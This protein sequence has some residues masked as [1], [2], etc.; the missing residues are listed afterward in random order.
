MAVKTTGK[1]W[2]TRT[3]QSR[4]AAL[5]QVHA[6]VKAQELIML[7]FMEQSAVH[8]ALKGVGHSCFA[9]VFCAIALVPPVSSGSV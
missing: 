7:R 9:L 6:A 3:F 4:E 8:L 1:V 2:N 5:E